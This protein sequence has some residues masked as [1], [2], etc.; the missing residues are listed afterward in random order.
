MEDGITEVM[1]GAEI[2]DTLGWKRGSLHSGCQD[3]GHLAVGMEKWVTA[4]CQYS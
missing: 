4:R 1:V 2:S 3:Y